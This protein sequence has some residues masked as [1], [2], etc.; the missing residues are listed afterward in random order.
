MSLDW[1]PDRLSELQQQGLLRRR[2]VITSLPG[3]RCEI[4]GKRLHNFAANDY[5]NLSHDP[6]LAAAA[7][8]ALESGGAGAQASALVCG[9]TP[10]HAA[11]EERIARFEGQPAALVFPTGYAANVGTLAALVGSGDHVY[12][13]QLNHASLVDGCRLSRATV[14]VYPHNDVAAL[15]IALRQTGPA[16]RRL[17]ASD[18]AFSMDGDVANLPALCDVAERHGAMLLIDEAHATG[19]FGAQGRGVAEWQGVEARPIVRVGTLSKAVGAL[20]GFVAGSNELID[21]LWNRA[22]TQIFSTAL[23]PATCA[24]ARAAFDIIEAEPGRRA[25]LQALAQQLRERLTKAGI[26]LPDGCC[27]PIVPVVLQDPARA[28]EVA[29]QLEEQGFLVGA[30]R[31]PSVPAGTSR[32]RITLSA[33]QTQADVKQL[34]IAV[35]QLVVGSD[36]EK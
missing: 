26:V 1:I 7:R 32:L 12:S 34:A 18:S 14:H 16:G 5:L 27:G 24:A 23:P 11:L 33:A 30:I 8:E 29:R 6:R 2:R 20:G 10:W 19:V 28:V 13:D 17:I 35:G 15:E 36:R 21:W 22:R 4:D 25:H 3:G 9:R 31:P